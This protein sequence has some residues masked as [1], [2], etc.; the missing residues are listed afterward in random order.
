MAALPRGLSP[1]ETKAGGSFS[2]DSGASILVRLRRRLAAAKY[3][4][5][6]GA[7]IVC[8]RVTGNFGQ[9]S[10][11][12]RDR[13]PDVGVSFVGDVSDTLHDGAEGAR[14]ALFGARQPHG[15]ANRCAEAETDGPEQERIFPSH[16]QNVVMEPAV[17]RTGLRRTTTGLTAIAVARASRT[18]RGAC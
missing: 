14:N 18:F 13:V 15:A 1:A 5:E 11:D 16:C 7:H 9:L 12:V 10:R 3:S 4:L 6:I 17:D 2:L 8:F